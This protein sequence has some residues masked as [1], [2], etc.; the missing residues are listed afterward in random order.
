MY[1]YTVYYI[2]YCKQSYLLTYFSFWIGNLSCPGMAPKSY[3][4]TEKKSL[5]CQISGQSRFTTRSGRRSRCF[6]IVWS[7]N[8][9]FIP[10]GR[11]HRYVIPYGN[12]RQKY[13]K[14]LPTRNGVVLVVPKK[15][16]IV[17]LF[18]VTSI[19]LVF[20]QA[21]LHLRTYFLLAR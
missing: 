7:G 14:P 20:G 3:S 11:L 18:F 8:K 1:V 15:G 21:A 6:R 9:S 5:P 13:D 4:R 2:S 10:F 17:L 19:Y 16:E 12:F